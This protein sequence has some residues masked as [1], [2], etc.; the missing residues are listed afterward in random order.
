MRR[1]KID[2]GRFAH[3]GRHL[4]IGIEA[5]VCQHGAEGRHYFLSSVC[6]G[7]ARWVMRGAMPDLETCGWCDEMAG[8]CPDVMERCGTTGLAADVVWADG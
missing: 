2:S 5:F 6:C 8:R 7:T 3:A 1:S 4:E